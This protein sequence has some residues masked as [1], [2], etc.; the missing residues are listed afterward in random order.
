MQ[1][2]LNKTDELEL[3]YK[4]VALGMSDI[5]STKLNL[6][7]SFKRVSV[8]NKIYSAFSQ[9][10]SQILMINLLKYK[11]RGALLVVEPLVLHRLTDKMLGGSG[12]GESSAFE[13]FSDS[14][15]FFNQELVNWFTNEYSKAE[16]GLDYI[17]SERELQ[18]IHFFFPEE[19]VHVVTLS[20]YINN[21]YAGQVIACHPMD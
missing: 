5:I 18:K 16:M 7:F 17:R 9:L 11:S 12:K 2:N 6:S 10:S 15:V 4:R 13:D 8:E 14:E 21:E 20:A 3:N 1:K 19:Q